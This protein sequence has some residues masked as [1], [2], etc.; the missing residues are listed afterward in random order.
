MS[1]Q[2]RRL[3][4]EDIRYSERD[5]YETEWL[6]EHKSPI[7]QWQDHKKGYIQ[8]YVYEVKCC[9]LLW[10]SSAQAATALASGYKDKKA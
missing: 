4:F 5:A 7:F 3:L 6:Y 8:V 2:Q 1:I 9:T 10:V